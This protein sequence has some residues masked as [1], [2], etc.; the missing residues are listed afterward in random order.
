MLERKKKMFHLKS[1][2]DIGLRNDDIRK[3]ISLPCSE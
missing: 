2:E 1:D 3:A